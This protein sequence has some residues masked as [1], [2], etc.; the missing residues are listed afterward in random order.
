MFNSSSVRM[1]KLRRND[2]LFASLISSDFQSFNS[3]SMSRLSD[4]FKLFNG[5][6]TNINPGDIPTVLGRTLCGPDFSVSLESYGY[7]IKPIT[8]NIDEQNA[9]NSTE[10][11]MKK[12][13]ITKKLSSSIKILY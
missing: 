8:V 1:V 7:T 11:P 5:M 4:L 13:K 6:N 2:S 12:N 9:T 10:S 3:S